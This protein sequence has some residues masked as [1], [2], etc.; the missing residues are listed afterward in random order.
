MVVSTTEDCPGRKY[1]WV[2]P[3]GSGY[4]KSR[5]KICSFKPGMNSVTGG[6]MNVSVFPLFS[7]QKCSMLA[8]VPSSLASTPLGAR[9]VARGEYDWV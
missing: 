4:L 9:A 2:T 6:T 1:S 3:T 5:R 7:I 8:D